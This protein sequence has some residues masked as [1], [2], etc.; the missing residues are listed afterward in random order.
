MTQRRIISTGDRERIKKNSYNKSYMQNPFKNL[1]NPMRSLRQTVSPSYLGVDIGTTSIKAVEVK[2][3]KKLPEV[4]NYGMLESRGSLLRANTAIQTSALKLFQTEVEDLLKT[5]L[6][7]MKPGTAEVVASLP[8]FSAFTTILSFPEMSQEELGKSI[9]FQAK[10]YIPLEISEAAIDWMKVGEY[11]DD[12]GFNF[13]QILLISVP[14]E[15]IR[16]YQHMFKGAGLNLRVLEIEQLSLARSL[17][18]TDPTPTFIVD[19]GSRSTLIT[20]A[21]RGAIHFTGQSDFAGSSLTQALASSLNINPL[22]AEELKKERG[23]AGTGANYELSTIML[24]FLDGIIDEVKRVESNYKSQV[25]GARPIERT[26]LSGGGA[27]LLGIEKYFQQHLG[28][29]VMKAAPLGKFEYSQ[30]I[31]PFVQE[32]NPFLSVSLGLALKEFA[33]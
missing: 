25:P 13:Q 24:P 28:I 18:G 16:K 5:L 23:I 4:I 17:I 12:K 2:Q 31:T 32:L 29:P 3:G 20:I 22:R 30:K 6:E 15:Q 7:Q 9:A 26:I 8:V 14:Q 21:D 27:N 1:F 10:Q 33:Q 19:I 11:R